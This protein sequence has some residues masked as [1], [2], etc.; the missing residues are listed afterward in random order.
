MSADSPD[1][2]LVSRKFYQDNFFGCDHVRSAVLAAARP[3]FRRKFIDVTLALE[4]GQVQSYRGLLALLSPWLG[5]L[6]QLLEE[7]V[8]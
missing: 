7:T 6:L 4:D 8:A 1:S 2:N 3:E 5:E